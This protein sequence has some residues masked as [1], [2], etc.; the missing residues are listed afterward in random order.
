ELARLEQALSKVNGRLTELREQVKEMEVG[1]DEQGIIE[2]QQLMLE[3]PQ[4]LSS[5]TTK[6]QLEKLNVEYAVAQTIEEISVY[7]QQ[8]EDPYFQAR[9]ADIHDLGTYLLHY[10]TSSTSNS[11]E[12]VQD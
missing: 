3:D 2:A 1:E 8:L 4:F 6:I 5:I 11:L 10:L 9:A 12:Q 7:F